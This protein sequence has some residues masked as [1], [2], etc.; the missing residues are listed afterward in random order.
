MSKFISR[1]DFLKGSAA[2]A[3]ATAFSTMAPAALAEEAAGEK[4]EPV[5]CKG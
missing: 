1:R 3:A 5:Y 2:L 4:L